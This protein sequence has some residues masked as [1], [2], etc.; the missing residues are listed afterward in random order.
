MKLLNYA[1]QIRAI[2]MQWTGI[3]ISI[4]IAPTKTLAKIANRVAKQDIKYRGIF[5]YP[6]WSHERDE[7][8]KA[9]AV[10]DIWGIG[11]QYSRWLHSLAITEA[12]SLR[13]LKECQIQPKMGIVGVRLLRELNAISCISLELAPKPK[14][15]QDPQLLSEAKSLRDAGAT[16][17]P[18]EAF[19][20]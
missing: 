2:V 16:R 5:I 20:F 8:L 19:G 18:S 15:R 9:I 17:R 6:D 3:P 12:L 13:N 4:G 7:V 10:E 14:K 11:R 1:K